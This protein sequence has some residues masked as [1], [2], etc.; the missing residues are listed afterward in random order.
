MPKS[1][2]NRRNEKQNSTKLAG[3]ISEGTTRGIRND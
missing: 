2:V 1:N 3:E